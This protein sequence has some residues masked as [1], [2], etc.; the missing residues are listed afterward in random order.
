[1]H[2]KIK[3]LQLDGNIQAFYTTS[4][5][6]GISGIFLTGDFLGD[7][8]GDGFGLLGILTTFI[9]DGV[10]LI[11]AAP[12]MGGLTV[13]VIA[14]SPLM[15][16]AL[17]DT[18]SPLDTVAPIVGASLL[19][20]SLL[21]VAVETT[22]LGLLIVVVAPVVSS[23]ALDF[24]SSTLVTVMVAQLLAGTDASWL[25]TTGSSSFLLSSKAACGID[26]KIS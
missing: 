2:I 14:T 13:L 22:S 11:G 17:G 20:T 1:M 26:H 23:L 12:S 16:L 9:G 24:A 5:L 4:K 15:P 7:F 6:P 18:F 21:T 3:I 19:P 8:F 10:F 25:S